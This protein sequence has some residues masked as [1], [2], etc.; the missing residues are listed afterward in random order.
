MNN[1]KGVTHCLECSRQG[2][3]VEID[4]PFVKMECPECKKTWRTIASLIIKPK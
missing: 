2:A 4:K 1:V 3:L